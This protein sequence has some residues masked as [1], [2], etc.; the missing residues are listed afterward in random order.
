[1]YQHTAL[2]K[3]TNKAA[4]GKIMSLAMTAAFLA[5]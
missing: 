3:P 4:N 5:K 1:M 2:I